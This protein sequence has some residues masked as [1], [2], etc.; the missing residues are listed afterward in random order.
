M[1]KLSLAACL[2]IAAV[3]VLSSIVA[4]APSL[5]IRKPPV[6][7]NISW[8]G[9][10]G[11]PQSTFGQWFKDKATGIEQWR[12]REF[13]DNLL[14]SGGG[15]AS[16]NAVKGVVNGIV[17]AGGPGTNILSFGIYATITND[18]DTQ[19]GT[20]DSGNNRHSENL[21]ITY[22]NEA[23]MY[24]V[25]LTASFAVD[26]NI[27]PALWQS[28][29]RQR[30]P[31]IIAQNYDV[32][33]WYCWTPNNP[34]GKTPYGA[35]YIPTYDFGLITYGQSVSRTLSF[36]V[37]A[38]LPNTDSR[39]SAIVASSTGGKD[40]FLNRTKS[41]K[42]SDWIDDLAL[43]S[44]AAYPPSPPNKASDVSVFHKHE[45]KPRDWG[46]A[47]DGPYPTW[48]INGGANHIILEGLNLGPPNDIDGEADGQPTANADGDDLNG[49][50]DDEES[51][52]S[53][54]SGHS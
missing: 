31:Y 38:G 13:Y 39:Y 33:A 43:D 23:W 30:T 52:N 6:T 11:D 35:Y 21:S 2:V 17:Y 12:P 16:T 51:D 48:A 10:P 41:L 15:N 20:W 18:T 8:T 46:D 14:G 29:Y 26:A 4:A 32:L 28:P 42:C 34:A 36:T 7:P 19:T 1:R 49:V 24:D 47:P 37:P 3:V 53:E 44:G 40:I 54:G 25:K 45:M 9:P 5:D 27:L 50:P 22:R